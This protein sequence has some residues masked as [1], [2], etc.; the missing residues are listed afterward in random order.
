MF[1]SQGRFF[2]GA[3]VTHDLPHHLHHYRFNRR[4]DSFGGLTLDD[5]RN[6]ADFSVSI[7]GAILLGG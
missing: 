7:A 1:Q 2:W 3:D 6:Q 4:G 5:E